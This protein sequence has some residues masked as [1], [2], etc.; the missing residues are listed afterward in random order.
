VSPALFGLALPLPLVVAVLF[1][2]ARALLDRIAG[3]SRRIPRW[4]G[5]LFVA[6]GLWSIWFA[7]FVAI[8][9]SA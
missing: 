5:A 1:A 9:G 2:P 3:L 8:A 7:L 4:T 6:L